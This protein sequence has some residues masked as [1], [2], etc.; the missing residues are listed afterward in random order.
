MKIRHLS[1][2]PPSSRIRR[3]CD[4]YNLRILA[5]K[6]VAPREFQQRLL[7]NSLP[8]AVLCPQLSTLRPRTMATLAI[9]HKSHPLP[10]NL[11]IHQSGSEHTSASAP[12]SQDSCVLSRTHLVQQQ[13]HPDG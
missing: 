5:L 9:Q 12:L 10:L 3:R 4:I 11:S 6:A 13:R 2:N 1:V 8:L 7:T